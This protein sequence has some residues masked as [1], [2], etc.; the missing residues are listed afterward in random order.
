[1]ALIPKDRLKTLVQDKS[2]SKRD[3]VLLFLGGLDGDG[4]SVASIRDIARVCGR[5]DVGDPKK[6]W[7]V[8]DILSR[9][10]GLTLNGEHGWE[11]TPD[12]KAHVADLAGVRLGG[13]AAKI[14][15]SNLRDQL[16]S[17]SSSNVRAFITESIEC[18]ESGL[19][20]S[21]V[22]LS[23]VGAVALLHDHVVQ[24]HLAQFN[25]EASRRDQK[26]RTAK[27]V[28]D[29]SRMK[30]HDFLNLLEALSIL[31]K[32]VKQDLQNTCLSLRNGCGHPNSMI[33]GENRVAA[34]IEFLI[35]NVYAKF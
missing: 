30:E 35:D 21:A 32:N 17:L 8:S 4:N 20:R 2:L 33:V 29:L 9:A 15:A 22:V 31:G 34:H 16:S 28:D 5:R 26:W 14:V 13:A 10:S 24:H 25:A 7:N 6:K 11:L 12:G 1:M 27:T 19:Y 18:F 3:T 23:W